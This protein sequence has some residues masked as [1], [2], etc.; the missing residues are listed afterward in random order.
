MLCLNLYVRYSSL[1]VL[2][3]LGFLNICQASFGDICNKFLVSCKTFADAYFDKI[4]PP[5]F[6][7]VDTIAVV[8][9]LEAFLW[10]NSPNFLL[11]KVSTNSSNEFWAEVFALFKF[12]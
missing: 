11:K 9:A 7:A 3:I 6:I 1:F 4:I 2:C 12:N 10:S 5:S 8:S